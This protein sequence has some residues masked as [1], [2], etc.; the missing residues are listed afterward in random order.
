MMLSQEQSRLAAGESIVKTAEWGLAAAVLAM[1]AAAVVGEGFRMRKRWVSIP[2]SAALLGALL[3]AIATQQPENIQAYAAP[4]GVYLV[5]AALT[6]RKS[7]PL[8]GENMHFHEAVMLGGFLL[9]V[10]PP[11]EQSF[12]PDGGKFGLEVLGIALLVLLV[13]L[14][15]HARWLVPA[16][17]VTLTAVSI[18]MVTGGMFQLPY[19][20]LLG[21]AGTLMLAF[22]FLVLLERERWD[23]FRHRVVE[24][25]IETAK[26]P[27]PLGPA[28]HS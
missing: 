3:M 10:L 23:R 8:F 18:R 28:L 13:G 16:A 14:G 26:P 6:F 1:A 7:P 4:I 15:F 21:L 9:M 24:W 27:G 5:F 20:L 12:A 17:I 2:G 25:W 11:A 19:W 22:G